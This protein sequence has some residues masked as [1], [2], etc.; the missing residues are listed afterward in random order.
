MKNIALNNSATQLLT[1]E[2]EQI[3]E[4]IKSQ[5]KIC[6]SCPVFE[7]IMDTKLFGFSEKVN[8]AIELDII[9]EEF[10]QQLLSD[11]ERSMSL[12]YEK[13]TNNQE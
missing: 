9:D 5:E 8:F 6:T 2:A 12:V 1:E 4:L 11:L 7:E 3:L 10:G 13:L